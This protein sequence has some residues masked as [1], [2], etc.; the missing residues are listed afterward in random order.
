[1]AVLAGVGY[2]YGLAFTSDHLNQPGVQASL[3]NWIILSYVL[4]GLVAWSRRPDSR[5]GPM[6]IV[7]GFV[8]FLTTLYWS[9]AAALSTIGLAFDYL[10]PVLFLH[11]FLAYPCRRWSVSAISPRWASRWCACCWARSGH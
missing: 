5:F 11:V 1:L 9:N 10:P 8:T 7:A 3:L 2:C 4:S 6:L